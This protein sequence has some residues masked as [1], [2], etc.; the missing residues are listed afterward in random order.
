MK[1]STATGRALIGQYL[2]SQREL[3]LEAGVLLYSCAGH[4]ANTAAAYDKIQLATH[5]G[6]MARIEA[7]RL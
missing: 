1:T 4:E 2:T 3:L 7:G 6:E 5:K